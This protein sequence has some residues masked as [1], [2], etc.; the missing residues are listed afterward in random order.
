MVLTGLRTMRYGA[1][2]AGTEQDVKKTIAYSTLSQLGF[3]MTVLGLGYPI[4]CFFHLVTHALFK[5]T[6]FISAGV[7]FMHRLHYQ[8]LGN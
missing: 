1:R 3:M 6:L 4:V 5:A 7:I 2:M 8:H